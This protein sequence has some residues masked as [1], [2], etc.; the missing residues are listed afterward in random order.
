MKVKS[1]ADIRHG[2][3]GIVFSMN[4]QEMPPPPT[5]MRLVYIWVKR[6]G[7]VQRKWCMDRIKASGPTFGW[8][9]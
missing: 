8:V 3:L 4:C 5:Q 9:V 2:T 6:D 1:G 7:S